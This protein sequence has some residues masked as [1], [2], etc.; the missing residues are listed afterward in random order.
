MPQNTTQQ[1]M[2]PWL[3]LRSAAGLSQREVERRLGWATEDGKGHGILSLIERGV[4]PTPEQAQQ[5]RRFYG[6]LL[7]DQ[8]GA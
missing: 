5:L 7:T 4:A 3:S 6:E 2:V 1:Q 8:A